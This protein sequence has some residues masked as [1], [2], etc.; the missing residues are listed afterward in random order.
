MKR[1]TTLLFALFVQL[2]VAGALSAQ[3]IKPV[4]RAYPGELALEVDLR[5]TTQRIWRVSETIPVKPG[6]VDLYYPKWIPGEHMPSGTLDR[7]TGLIVKGIVSGA[8]GGPR[9]PWRRDLEDMYTLHVDV[10]DGMV[11][12][13]LEFQVL[14][15]LEGGNFGASAAATNKMLMLEWNQV[16]FY[17]AGYFA[18]AVRVRPSVQLPSSWSFATALH[19]RGNGDAPEFDAV[20]LEDL[21]DSPLLAAAH[22][23]RLELATGKRLVNLNLAADHAEDLAVS[24]EQLKAYRNLVSQAQLL[25]GAEHY[26]HYDFLYTLSEDMG[27]FGLEHHQSSDDRVHADFFTAG[28]SYLS[29]ASLLPHEYVHS[30]NGKFRRPADLWTPHYNT[31]MHDDL[32]WVYEGLTEYYGEVLTARAGLYAPGQFHDALAAMAAMMNNRPGR[33]WRPLQ[34][35]A[36][37]AQILYESPLAWRSSHRD[38]D[39]YEEGAL[40]WLDADTLIREQSQGRR[41][42]DDFAR[43]FYGSDDGSRAVKTYTFN[44]VV[45]ALNQ[46]QPYDWAQFFR[47]RLDTTQATTLLDGVKRG[48]WRLVY[49]DTPTDYFK[50][51]EK[52]RK[53]VN[54][55]D[56]LGILIDADDKPGTVLDVLWNGP[57]FAAGV[58]P[59]MTIV[60]VNGEKYD[61]DRLKAIVKAAADS[62]API[63]LLVQN[64]NAFMTLK[65]DYHGGLKYPRL[66]RDE[67]AADR[68]GDIIQ[69]REIPTQ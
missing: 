43:L 13:Q 45:K 10:P 67:R 38:V 37:A 48:G 6:R 64:L 59:G 8:N 65:I 14:A 3:T 33:A 61:A 49:T 7:V 55:Y 60:A 58:A 11:A 26:D 56:S 25:F 18:R 22:F 47:A 23:K 4:D 39:F 32:L 66:E 16:V 9:L 28:D 44:D 68:I 51:I 34:D 62:Q 19:A 63:E 1:R 42:L 54:L 17:P 12:L 29:R 40:I 27:S 50:A 46:V 31:P 15:G 2:F 53:R 36:D 21:V 20:S 69:A 5:D 41:S 35:T 24:D 57:A 52:A 30:W